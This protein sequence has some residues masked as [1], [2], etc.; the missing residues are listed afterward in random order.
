MTK[1]EELAHKREVL[2]LKEIIYSTKEENK[3]LKDTIWSLKRTI[4][5]LQDKI[6]SQGT[7]V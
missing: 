3:A 2:I 4:G 7:L 6:D 1:E 5:L